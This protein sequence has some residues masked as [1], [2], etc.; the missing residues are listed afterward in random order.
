MHIRRVNG[1]PTLDGLREALSRLPRPKPV[2]CA[3]RRMTRAGGT[4]HCRW[5]GETFLFGARYYCPP[6]GH[7]LLAFLASITE[8][9]AA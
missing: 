5:R 9:E 2:P 7:S 4:T 6:H 1:R 8:D 3:H